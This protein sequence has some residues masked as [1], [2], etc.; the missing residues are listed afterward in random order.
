[1]ALGSRNRE[2][3]STIVPPLTVAPL[4][5]VKL[6]PFS[7]TTVPPGVPLARLTVTKLPIAIVPVLVKLGV[8]MLRTWPWLA[9]TVRLPWKT[10]PSPR[11][12]GAGDRCRGC[13]FG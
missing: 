3:P 2:P 6:P 11:T 13:R 8:W 5:T 9:L 10:I 4:P 1:M 7:V 12:I